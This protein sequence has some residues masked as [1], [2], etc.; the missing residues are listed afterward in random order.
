MRLLDMSNVQARSLGGETMARIVVEE[1]RYGGYRIECDGER[2]YTTV[3]GK[4]GKPEREFE[5]GCSHKH[6]ANLLGWFCR[7]LG[8]E[9]G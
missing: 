9:L 4:K 3:F 6:P 1:N 2:H 5:S 7:W 8:P